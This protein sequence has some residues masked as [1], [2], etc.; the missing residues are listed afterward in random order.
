MRV[1]RIGNIGDVLQ[2]T[3]QIWRSGCVSIYSFLL[4]QWVSETKIM[5]CLIV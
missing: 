1:V 3:V 5:G 2:P 4:N